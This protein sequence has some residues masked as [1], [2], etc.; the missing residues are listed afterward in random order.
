MP[1][2]IPSRQE[3]REQEKLTAEI[4]KL[5]R[6]AA[7]LDREAEALEKEA[8]CDSFRSEGGG[9]RAVMQKRSHIDFGTHHARPS[10]LIHRFFSN[11][12]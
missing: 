1:H 6:E 7:T 9:S 5:D 2:C 8:P 11:R 4:E 3:E 12:R 10:S